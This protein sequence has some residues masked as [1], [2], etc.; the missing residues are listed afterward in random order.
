MIESLK[1]TFLAKELLRIANPD[2]RI[3]HTEVRIGDC[4]VMI[5]DRQVHGSRCLP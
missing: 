4:V 1:Q 5:S 3:N 2:G